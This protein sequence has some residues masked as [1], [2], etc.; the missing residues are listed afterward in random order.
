[1]GPTP[2]DAPRGLVRELGVLV[3]LGAGGLSA[4]RLAQ[5]VPLD[6]LSLALHLLAALAALRLAHP[7][8]TA[9][10]PSLAHETTVM[11]ALTPGDTDRSRVSP[12]DTFDAYLANPSNVDGA[13]ALPAGRT[14]W[15]SGPYAGLVFA[16][17]LAVHA[18]LVPLLRTSL[19][20]ALIPVACGPLAA[21]WWRGRGVR[22][23]R[24]GVALLLTPDQL[25]VRDAV[26]ARSAAWSEVQ[27]VRED[28]RPTWDMLRGARRAPLLLISRR[29]SQPLVLGEDELGVPV[30][31]ALAAVER[32]RA[33]VVSAS[34]PASASPGA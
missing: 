19:T 26:G 13:L 14:W 21:W 32:Y 27:A 8:A 18:G 6:G 33:A 2:E 4:A 30:A 24:R 1:M 7:L 22:R 31:H 17:L 15:L 16:V 25:I 12:A 23:A 28:S 20:L 3:L 29:G 34:T 9:R 10:Q 5:G 11:P